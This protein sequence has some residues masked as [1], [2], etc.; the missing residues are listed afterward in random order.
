MS[1]QRVQMEAKTR[2][3]RSNRLL[4][5]VGSCNGAPL[6]PLPTILDLLSEPQP[7]CALCLELRGKGKASQA[8]RRPNASIQTTHH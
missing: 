2:F 1:R 7:L 5:V 3:D 8:A 6:P 4:C